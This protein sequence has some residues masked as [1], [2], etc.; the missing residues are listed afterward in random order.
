MEFDPRELVSSVAEYEHRP[1]DVYDDLAPLYDVVHARS[2][3]Y[4]AQARF[5]EGVAPAAATR[6]LDGACGTGRL[7][8]VLEGRF[9][10]AVGLDRSA[11]ML[12]VAAGNVDAPLVRA[13]L[14]AFSADEPFDVVAVFG[15]TLAE[16]VDDDDLR[17]LFAGVRGY[18]A[19]DGVLVCDFERRSDAVNGR[20]VR[21]SFDTGGLD[22]ERTIVETLES[23]RLVRFSFA[24]EVAAHATGET[25]R[26]G[27]SFRGRAFDPEELIAA[28]ERE[29]FSAATVRDGPDGDPALVAER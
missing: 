23:E 8:A 16:F 18:L 10:V 21:D 4:E 6:V 25:A 20:V 12:D 29:G 14:A 19:D 27:E 5:V 26:A 22:V 13:D 24:Y 15:N 3:D 1:V 28:A 17:A 9:E 2:V 11:G 7:L